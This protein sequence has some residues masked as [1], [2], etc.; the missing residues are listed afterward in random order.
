MAVEVIQITVYRCTCQHKDCRNIWEANEIPKRCYKC[1]RYS[2]Y[3]LDK[4]KWK[5]A[6]SAGAPLP[7]DNAVETIQKTVYRCT[8]EHE[9]CRYVWNAEKLPRRCANCDRYTWNGS[10]KRKWQRV[11]PADAPLPGEKP[12]SV[13]SSQPSVVSKKPRAL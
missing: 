5:S 2:W 13:V 4:R 6:I 11:P 7:Q 8:C 10:D 12:Q 1:G 3:G 9:D